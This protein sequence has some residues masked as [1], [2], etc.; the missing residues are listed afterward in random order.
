MKNLLTVTLTVMLIGIAI[1]SKSSNNPIDNTNIAASLKE[2]LSIVKKT[3]GPTITITC[4]FGRGTECSRKGVCS[5]SI[6][7]SWSVKPTAS[8]DEGAGTLTLKVSRNY[9]NESQPDKMEN[10]TGQT[11]FIVEQNYT[12]SQEASVALGADH[13]LVIKAGS[14]RMNFIGDIY[15]IIIGDML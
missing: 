4:T 8:Y 10:F 7:G 6:G 9:I 1:P 5:I 14:Y 3:G 12:L 11:Q 15:T 2:K 13:I